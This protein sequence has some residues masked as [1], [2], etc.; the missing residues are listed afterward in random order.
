MSEFYEGMAEVFEIEASEIT[1]DFDLNSCETAWDSLA[2]IST[3]ALVDR[4]F[5]LT[6]NGEKLND[7][8][9]IS[10][11]EKLIEEARKGK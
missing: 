8:K 4:C 6:L 3:I 9:A 1:S 5:G 7:C 10:D 2:V 11:I